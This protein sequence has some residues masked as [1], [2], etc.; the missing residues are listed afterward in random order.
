MK[1]P[2]ENETGVNEFKRI[3]GREEQQLEK[4]KRERIKSETRNFHS[5]LGAVIRGSET[6]VEARRTM[7]KKENDHPALKSLFKPY[8]KLENVSD[9]IGFF[10]ATKGE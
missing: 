5:S 9:E 3:N 1:I 6:F 7:E 10:R 8:P 4:E 2:W